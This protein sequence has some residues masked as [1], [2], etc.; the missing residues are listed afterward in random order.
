LSEPCLSTD[1][2]EFM[3]ESGLYVAVIEYDSKKAVL[4]LRVQ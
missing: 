1:Y 3:V 2:H 4:K